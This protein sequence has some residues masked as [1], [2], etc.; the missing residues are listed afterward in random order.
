MR[1]HAVAA[2]DRYSEELSLRVAQDKTTNRNN[3]NN[4]NKD[5]D[6]PIMQPRGDQIDKDGDRQRNG[7]RKP[8]GNETH[9]IFYV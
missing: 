5:K 9:I 7:D 3:N 1:E 6:E 2:L 4:N 8:R